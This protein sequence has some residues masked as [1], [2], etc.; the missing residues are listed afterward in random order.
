MKRTIALTCALGLAAGSPLAAPAVPKTA[1]PNTVAAAPYQRDAYVIPYK[2]FVLQN[3]LT[4]IVHEDHS[5]PIVGVN[6]WYHVGSRNEKR[7]KTGFAHLFE[8]FFFNGSENYPHGFREAM[9]DLGTNNRNGTTNN[10]RTNFFEDVPVSAL[11]RTLYLEADRMGFLANYIS[12]EMLERER[13]VVQNEKRQ[14][15]NQPYGR[16]HLEK[17]ARMYPYSHPY[18][19]P[20]IGSMDDLNAASLEDI[21]EWYRTYYGPNNAVVSLAG[22]ITPEQALALVKKYFE[23]IPPGPPLPRTEQWIPRLERNLRDEMEDHVPQVRIYRSWHVPGWRDLDSTRLAVFSDVLAGSKNAR[24][25]RRLIDEKQLATAVS[26]G[27]DVNELSSTFDI[28]VTVRPGVDPALVEKE[29]DAVL[30]E[31]LDKGP[32]AQ[33]VARVK[34]S[35]LASFARGIERLGGFGGRS[36]VLAESVTYGGAPDAYLRQLD[37]LT[38]VQ[39]A[40]LKT[41]AATWLRAPHYTMTV[42][43]FAKLSAAAQAID[44]KVLPALGDAPAVKFPAMQQATLSNGLKVRLLERHVAPIVNVALAFDAGTSADTPAKAGLASLT[45]ELLDKGTRQRDAYQMSDALESLGARLTTGT[46]PDMSVMRLQ[47]TSA[48]LAPSLALLAEAALAPAFPADQFAL[49]KQ[50]RLAGIAQEKAQPNALAL[51]T[52]PALLYGADSGYGL[53]PSGFEQSVASLTREDLVAWHRDW[54]KPGSAAIVVS[55]DTTLDKVVPMLEAAFGKWPAGQAPA[56]PKTTDAGLASAGKRIYLID[57]PDAPQSTLLAGHLSLPPGQPED[58]AMEPVMQ[59]FGGMATSRLN[60]NLRLDK[61]WSYGGGARLSSVRGPRNF[62]TLIAVQTDKT[63]ESMI[64]VDKEIRGIAGSR[65]IQGD[66]FTSIMRNMTSRLAGRFET[67]NALE[68]AALETINLG[69]PEDY[70]AN[71]APNMRALTP[72]QL[73]GAAGKFIRPED[74]TW[75]VVGDLKKIEPR[76]RELGWGDVI[77]LDNDGKRVR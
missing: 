17:S 33:E 18:S 25:N 24:L 75:V 7:G 13:G 41:V 30:N 8:H 1:A 43:P 57:K 9:D 19:W 23:S 11:E 36:D 47:A 72:P 73:A 52:L 26:A 77:V 12:K 67:I 61:H 4:L 59:N 69:L 32:T 71:Y 3:G 46:G 51:R 76:I 38:A 55:G 16:V 49:A 37:A 5:V 35:A 39:P 21:R 22:D 2:K 50:R 27:V 28:A 14:G 74:V 48:N 6:I 64:E 40:Q 62:Y 65:P 15:E 53:P 20:V 56:K 31:A 54:F 42:K 68:A 60:R 45:L 44:R 34:A 10:D 63:K 70:W 29:L 58:L 66:E